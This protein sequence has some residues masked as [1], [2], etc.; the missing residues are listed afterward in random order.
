MKQFFTLICASFFTLATYGQDVI[1]IHFDNFDEDPDQRL[2]IE[3][4]DELL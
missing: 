2:P 3:K 1:E 4:N